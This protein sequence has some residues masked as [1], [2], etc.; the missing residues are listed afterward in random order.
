MAKFSRKAQCEP[1]TG[2][3]G[4]G[5][6]RAKAGAGEQGSARLAAFHGPAWGGDPDGDRPAPKRRPA[7]ALGG[8]GSRGAC[9]KK[10]RKKRRAA[11][12]RGDVTAG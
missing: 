1:W 6:L 2:Q 11:A 3:D 10:K 9:C 4:P 7:R 12:R 5:G 8:A